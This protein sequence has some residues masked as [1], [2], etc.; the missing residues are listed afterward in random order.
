MQ[1]DIQAR[2]FTLTD[3]LRRHAERQQR[4]ALTFFARHIP[5]LEQ[6]N[7]KF[8]IQCRA[9]SLTSAIVGHMRDRLDALA[10]GP[11]SLTSG[12]ST[13]FGVLQPLFFSPGAPGSRESLS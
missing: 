5:G 12:A 13:A 11:R 6:A 3:S 4:F 9:L 2:G 10:A 1:I 7:M 8:A